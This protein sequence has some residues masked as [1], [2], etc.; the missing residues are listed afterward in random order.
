MFDID[1][2]K[3]IGFVLLIV[4]VIVVGGFFSGNITTDDFKKQAIE[5]NCAQYNP[6]TGKFEWIKK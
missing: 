4:L 3:I 5:N 2:F 6:T 1:F